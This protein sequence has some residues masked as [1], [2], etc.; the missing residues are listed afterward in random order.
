MKQNQTP[1]QME[2]RFT[3]V[4]IPCV[5]IKLQNA[6]RPFQNFHSLSP[7][8]KSEKDMNYGFESLRICISP[9]CLR[10]RQND[11]FKLI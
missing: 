10:K 9:S 2:I 11:I 6:K 7:E 3:C 1:F 5:C 4:P 8:L